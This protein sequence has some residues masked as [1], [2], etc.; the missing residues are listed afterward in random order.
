[1]I[2]FVIREVHEWALLSLTDIVMRILALCPKNDFEIS[3][4]L[5]YNGFLY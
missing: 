4:K 3:S 5:L 2:F 1:M